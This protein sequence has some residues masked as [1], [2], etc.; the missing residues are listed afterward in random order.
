MS[1]R[2]IQDRL[3]QYACK[4]AIE[5]EQALR[6]ITQ[7]VVLAALGRTDFFAQAA[8]QGGT[9]LRV[10][11]GLNRFSE[12][13]DFV[14]RDTNQAFDLRPYLR[15]VAEELVAYGYHL[16]V[17][18]PSRVAAVV[19]KAFLKDDSI[20]RVLDLSYLRVDRSTRKIRV[21]LEVDT[22]PPSGSG[23]EAKFLDF[24]FVSSVLL[25]DLPSLFAGKLHALLCREYVKG[26]D[27]YDFIWYTGRST[28][29]NQALLASAIRQQGPWQDQ[30]V[31]ADKTWCVT[32][33]RRVI[34][35]IDWRKAAEDV[36]RFLP[37]N[38]LPSL[39]HWSVELFLA[40]AAKMSNS[41]S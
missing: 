38:E 7:E 16:E 40:Q 11:Y 31:Q 4:S 30:D 8:L 6:E 23:F 27:W 26:R 13:L 15:S 22:H 12:D 33:L 2:L 37:P 35:S 21:K 24:P 1:I 32:E 39:E 34:A 36:R 29:I 20:C 41:A 18:D 28:P 3:N 5:E 9:C 19:K 25:Q 10:F 14:L 17:Q